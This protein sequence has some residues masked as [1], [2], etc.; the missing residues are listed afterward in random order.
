MELKLSCGCGQNYKFDIEPRDGR[1]PFTVACPICGIDGTTAADQL[2]AAQFSAAPIPAPPPV[3]VRI[4]RAAPAEPVA[5]APA[6]LPAESAPVVPA[7]APKSYYAKL[8]EAF[9]YPFKGSGVMILII[10]TICYSAVHFVS[11]G[12]FGLI[13]RTFL[14]GFVFL[15]MQNIILTTTTNEKEPLSFPDASGLVGAASQLGGTILMSFWPAIALEIAKLSDVNIP[16]E[17][18]I[19]AVILGGIYFPMALL[20]VAMKDTVVAANPLIV[21][22]AMAKAPMKYSV[23]AALTL[24][25]FGVR[26]LGNILSGTAGTVTFRTHD[27]NVFFMAIA[28]QAIWALLSV[29]LLTVMMRI[30]GLFYN[31]TKK[32]LGWF[33]W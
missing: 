22:P 8:P 16:S 15:F 27:M 23:T 5:A 17:A 11:A 13:M 9:A 19:A 32:Q 29:Y 33:S 1:M 3:A 25:V 7:V 20:V 30:L 2:L 10:A 6:P 14:Y 28:Y 26:Q 21:I 4:R 18:I 12:L 24:V 31:S